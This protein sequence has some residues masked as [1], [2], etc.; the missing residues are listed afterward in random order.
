MDLALRLGRRCA[1]LTAENPA[2]GC[3]IVAESA[4]GSEVIGRGWTQRG[5]RPHAERVALA[6]AGDRAR[7]ATAYVTLEPCSHHGKSP[8]CAE[9]LI[10]A[11]IAK[12]ICAH[13]DPDPRVAGRG[14]AMLQAAGIKTHM[15]P[16]RAVAHQ[17]LAGFLSRVTRH[18]PWLMAKMALSP[19][20]KIGRRDQPNWPV[21]GG[22]AKARTY[23]LRS[24]ADAIIVGIGTVLVDN[25]SLTVRSPGLADRSPPR[26]VLDSKGSIPL[27][28]GLV[29]TA[30]DI[31]TWILATG[32]IAADKA[33][34]LEE[35]GCRV[36]LLEADEMGRLDLK[37]S[38][39]LLAEEGI[40][41]AMVEPGATLAEALL[42]Q[43][44][45]DEFILY[46][47]VKTVG[48]QGLEALGG[49]AHKALQ[50]GGFVWDKQEQLGEDIL[51]RY[52]RSESLSAL[53]I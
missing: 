43:D 7:G 38:L 28:S 15:G 44:L 41:K 47:G 39:S 24:Q 31:P 51:H 18:R 34:M 27:Q 11:G 9:A 14:L 29:Q 1:G 22:G 48:P 2:V 35:A 46:R 40:N 25:P 3:V 37:E 45:I 33:L 26:I 36:F 32:L 49:N 21:T 42:A 13:P 12:V 23:G 19:D 8:P 20:H 50:T 4:N 5:G 10:Q 53:D 52:L 30:K 6:E 16:G 17:D